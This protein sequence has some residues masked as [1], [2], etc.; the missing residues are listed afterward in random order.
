[1]HLMGSKLLSRKKT[2]IQK[3][4]HATYSMFTSGVSILI[5]KSL[6]SVVEQVHIDPQGKYAILVFTLWGI[7][8]VN[9]NVY[10]PP[11]FSLALLY[12]IL[13]WPLTWIDPHLLNIFPWIYLPGLRQWELLRYGDGSI[14][15]PDLT[16]VFPQHTKRL[17]E[18]TW[19]LPILLCFQMFECSI[20][21][22]SSRIIAPYSLLFAPPLPEPLPFG[23]WGPTGFPTQI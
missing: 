22:V 9:V 1:M 6:L 15:Q 7:R 12:A 19:T 2:W 8:Y 16:L 4:F 11:P 5:S 18:L 14:L 13:N 17:I 20:Y 23:A 3:T 21:L 10:I